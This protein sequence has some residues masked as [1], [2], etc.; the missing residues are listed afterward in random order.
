VATVAVEWAR[1]SSARGQDDAGRV[2]AARD[3]S[4]GGVGDIEDGSR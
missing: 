1:D 3:G 2:T 4:N